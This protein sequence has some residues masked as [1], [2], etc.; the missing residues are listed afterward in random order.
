M[1]S[2]TAPFLHRRAVL[3]RS[4]NVQSLKMALTIAKKRVD[5]AKTIGFV[6]LAQS[7]QADVDLVQ[8]RLSAVLQRNVPAIVAVINGGSNARC[9]AELEAA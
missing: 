5:D 8:A 2:R 7:W 4:T 6:A 1:P 9:G 3:A